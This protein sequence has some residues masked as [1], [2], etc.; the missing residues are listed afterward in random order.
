MMDVLDCAINGNWLS[1]VSKSI[2][3]DDISEDSPAL[4]IKALSM[5]TYDGQHVTQ[6]N[7]QK[8]AVTITFEIHEHSAAVRKMINADVCKWA[9]NGWLSLY[10]RPYQK[11]YVVCDKLP[12]ISSSLKWTQKM[13]VGFAAYAMPF[14]QNTLPVK[15]TFTGTTGK[16]L[17]KP[18]GLIDCYLEAKISATASAVNSLT[19]TANGKS[20]S[21][22][23]LKLQKGQFL[24]IGYE[25]THH[26]QTMTIGGASVLSKR[27]AAS[28]DDLF[29]TPRKTNEI[30]V[31]ADQP[32]SATFLAY[33][34]YP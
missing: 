29:L 3:I 12:S 9:Q 23:G 27:S 32:V 22:S 17:I 28:A 34:L 14:W 11:L 6:K 13:T 24:E 2:F 19:I 7:R 18:D 25:S 21:F 31:T 20:Y 1:A 4:Q 26:I 5:A 15:A 33:G 16:V 8:L 30:S 10:D